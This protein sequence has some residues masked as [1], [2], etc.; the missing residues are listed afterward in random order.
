M[1]GTESK[2]SA[3]IDSAVTSGHLCSSELSTMTHPSYLVSELAL[4]FQFSINSIWAKNNLNV[5]G[6]DLLFP[7]TL[8]R[9]WRDGSAEY[10]LQ[11]RKKK[12]RI[13]VALPKD[14]GSISSTHLPTC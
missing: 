13:L 11:K 1:L 2:Y 4:E 12:K 7:G 9:G 14:L 5:F 3:S 10:L 6:M 8:Q